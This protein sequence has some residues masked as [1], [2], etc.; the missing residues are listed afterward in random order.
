[1]VTSSE[2]TY[3]VTVKPLESQD[4]NALKAPLEGMREDTAK[5]VDKY[6]KDQLSETKKANEEERSLWERMTKPLSVDDVKS[7]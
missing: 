7:P 3:P 5:K 2:T 4:L 1:M 6:H